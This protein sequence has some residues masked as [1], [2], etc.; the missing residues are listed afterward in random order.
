MGSCKSN[1]LNGEEIAKQIGVSRSTVY[2]VIN[3]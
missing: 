2:R 1:R 3:H